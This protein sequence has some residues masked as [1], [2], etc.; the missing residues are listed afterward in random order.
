MLSNDL[1]YFFISFFIYLIYLTSL[2]IYLFNYLFIYLFNL[3]RSMRVWHQLIQEYHAPSLQP[4]ITLWS[5]EYSREAF[6]QPL[7]STPP[8]CFTQSLIIGQ[9]HIFYPMLLVHNAARQ[10]YLLCRFVGCMHYMG[11]TPVI[12]I[13]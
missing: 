3:K 12:S 7:S 11:S 2:F 13:T 9:P 6:P 1:I 4:L 10:R 5:H 8:A